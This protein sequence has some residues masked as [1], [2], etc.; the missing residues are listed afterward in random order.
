[1]L[2]KT[3]ITELTNTKKDQLIP[4]FSGNIPSSKKRAAQLYN[5]HII[6]K[7]LLEIV[8][9]MDSSS[10]NNKIDLFYVIPENS[11]VIKRFL[12]VCTHCII[13]IG[14]LQDI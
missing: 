10:I 14:E 9:Y 5:E 2:Y 7:M 1:M 12:E 11:S 13:Y 4:C 6:L 8:A 3:C